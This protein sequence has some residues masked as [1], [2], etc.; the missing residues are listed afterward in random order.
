V[1]FPDQEN[2]I[3][4]LQEMGIAVPFGDH[5]MRMDSLSE[6]PW[7]PG[8][9]AAAPWM[10][11]AM[12][13]NRIGW[14]PAPH[15]NGDPARNAGPD[16]AINNTLDAYE[17]ADRESSIKDK[18]WYVEHVPFATPQQ[19]DR[20]AKLGIIVS[21][22][23][24]GYNPG[25]PV[26]LPKERFEHQNPVREFLEHKLVVIGGS[27]Y[28]GPNPIEKNPNNPMIPFYFYVTRKSRAG[29]IVAGDEKISRE[30]ALRIF[31][32]NPA[33]A[34]FEE[35]VKGS[36]APG[37]LADFVILNQ[38]IMTVPDDKLLETHPLATFV[39]GKKVYSAENTNF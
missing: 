39:G 29:A 23:D 8:T 35:K 15:V 20:M 19:I 18:R 27:D 7:T 34:T 24:S 13:L 26:D 10:D 4:N 2:T 12:A 30:D 38:D 3:K 6:E 21:I 14:R 1:E 36:I 31:T 5:W 28:S 22:Q 33:Y 32:V 16:E 9:M 25:F 17:A 37:M 11:F